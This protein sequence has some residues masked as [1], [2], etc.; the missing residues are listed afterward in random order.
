MTNGGRTYIS[1]KWVVWLL[2]T[3]ISGVISLLINDTRI[4]IS[5]AKDRIEA[6]QKEKVDNEQYQRDIKEIKEG[7][8]FLIKREMRR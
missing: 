6:L 8:D 5:E 3:I 2:I 1:W 4:G 7:L